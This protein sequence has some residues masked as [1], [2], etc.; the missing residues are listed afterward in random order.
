MDALEGECAA[1]VADFDS[2]NDAALSFFDFLHILLPCENPALR[3][4]AS[5]RPTY[6]VNRFDF[7]PREVEVTVSRLLE[8]ELILL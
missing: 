2:N 5:Q 7:L 1:I 6:E 8:H 3:A 4:S